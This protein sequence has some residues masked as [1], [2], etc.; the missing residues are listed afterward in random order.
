MNIY[1]GNMSYNTTEDRLR[2]AFADFGEVSTVN[3]IT[4]RYGGEPKGL[5]VCGNVVKE[6]SHSC[7]QR[8]ERPGTRRAYVE[9]RRGEATRPERQPQRW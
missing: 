1:G 2:Q 7:H 9:H 8:P 3:I 4:D 6:R 5:C